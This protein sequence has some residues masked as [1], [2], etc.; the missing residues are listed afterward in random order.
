MTTTSPLSH[1]GDE[2][3]GNVSF[4]RRIQLQNESG[5]VRV[6]VVTGNSLRGRL[7]RIAAIRMCDAL[8]VASLHKKLYHFLFSGGTIG[9]GDTKTSHDIGGLREMRSDIPFIGLFGGAWQAEI[10]PGS[11]M[12]GMI[13]PSCQ[14]TKAITGITSA[15]TCDRIIEQ[16]YYSR[17][18]DYNGSRYCTKDDTPYEDS[19]QM[20][21]ESETIIPGIKL[22]GSIT[23]RNATPLEFG[24]LID[25]ISTWLQDN[26]YLGGM[27]SKGHGKVLIDPIDFY[28]GNGPL[29]LDEY[30]SAYRQH[31]V[32]QRSQMTARLESMGAKF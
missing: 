26:P 22:V 6:P 15:V 8:S 21:Y 30:V 1:F 14:E 24:C 7:R 16:V 29:D 32:D 13:W 3:A 25:A 20:I 9:K 23:V 31:L 18:D 4:F 17:R 19:S 11:L 2:K 28:N 27:N 10:L 5:I 12:V